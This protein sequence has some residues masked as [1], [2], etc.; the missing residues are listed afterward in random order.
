MKKEVIHNVEEFLR[1]IEAPFPLKSIRTF[2]NPNL[3]LNAPKFLTELTYEDPANGNVHVF[4]KSTL[5]VA[6]LLTS[7]AKY[8]RR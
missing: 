6:R 3:A 8:D 1:S 7:M 4:T 2:Q 5:K